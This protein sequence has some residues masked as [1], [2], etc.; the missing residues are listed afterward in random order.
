MFTPPDAQHLAVI[1][2]YDGTLAPIVDDPARAVALPAALDALRELVDVVRLVAVV[3][4]RP[5]SFLREHLP[6]EGV[7]LVGQY[8]LERLVDGDIVADPRTAPYV[9]DVASA[10]EEAEQRWP[11]LLIER[12]GKI[13]CTVHWRAR[14]HHPS[15]TELQRLADRHGLVTLSSRLACELRP[16]VPVDKGVAVAQLLGTPQL[17]AAVF[18]GDDRGD[19]RAFD[20]L[21]RRQLEDDGEF[22]GVRVAVGSPEAPPE[23]L[24]RADVIVDGPE[25]VA[26]F[27]SSLVRR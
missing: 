16:P 9:P 3:S 22:T 1:S 27:L 8:G 17:E 25:G 20:A 10:A 19:L 4:G 18:I 12:K 2:D 7:A 23:L 13:A 14:P 24:E 26:A 15:A 11:E 6:I 5:V 21:D